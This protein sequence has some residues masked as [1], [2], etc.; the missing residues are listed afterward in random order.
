M[1]RRRKTFLVAKPARSILCTSRERLCEHNNKIRWEFARNKNSNTRACLLFVF[2]KINETSYDIFTAFTLLNA[3]SALTQISIF[4][5]QQLLLY[6]LVLMAQRLPG[7]I[8]AA[9]EPDQVPDE[10]LLARQTHRQLLHLLR[11]LT[12]EL[13]NLALDLVVNCG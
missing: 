13:F 3:R 2:N 9:A 12:A 10:D 4:A 1:V 8:L 5:L 6:P 7:V 11:E